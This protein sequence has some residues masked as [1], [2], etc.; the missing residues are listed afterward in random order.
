MPYKALNIVPKLSYILGVSYLFKSAIVAKVSII[1][2]SDFQNFTNK[3]LGNAKAQK[4]TCSMPNKSF[5]VLGKQKGY[6]V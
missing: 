6:L 1:S 5:L 4:T 2:V 3:V